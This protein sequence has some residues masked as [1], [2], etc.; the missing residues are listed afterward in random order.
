VPRSFDPRSHA[1][2]G[3]TQNARTTVAW[4]PGR[5]NLIGEHT[6]Y[7]GGLCLPFA[8]EQGVTVEAR[9]ADGPAFEAVALDVG[10][11]DEFLADVADAAHGW[12]SFVR[13]TVAELRDS[14]RA[15]PPAALEISG[16]VPQGAGLSSSAALAVALA[17]A[18]LD[19]AG[20]ATP[21]RLAL[22]RLCSRVENEWVRAETGLL[23]QL[24]VLMARDGCALRIDF[25]TL[26]IAPIPLDLRRWKL[27]TVDSGVS[28]ALSSGGYNER[29]RE[30]RQACEALGVASLREATMADAE[31]LPDPLGRR[32]RHVLTE[33]DRVDAMVDAL[34]A[35]DL[36]AAGRLLDASHASLR[37]DYEVSV[38]AVEHAVRRMKAAGAAG[39]RVVGGGFGGHVL[40]LFPPDATPPSDAIH[41]QPGPGAQLLGRWTRPAKCCSRHRP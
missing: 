23:D 22:A 15:V 11:R 20:D 32:V 36:D 4:A 9:R 40:G 31:R 25:A 19:L 39:A 38:P 30:C 12:R 41:V 5:V 28:R 14:G 18:L 7:N 33:N 8:I 34:G 10:E 13:G 6:D 3:R 24:A 21:D 37:D 35:S 17:L 2:R 1:G 27:V 29:R 26:D 16:D